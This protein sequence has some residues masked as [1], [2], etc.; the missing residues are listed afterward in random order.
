MKEKILVVE[1]QFVEADYLSL[2]LRNAGYTVT[3]IARSVSQAKEMI[4]KERPG[5]VLLDIYLKGSLTGIELGQ[6]LSEDSI[7]FVYVSANS[8]QEVLN[9]AK[10]TQPYGFIVKPFREQDLLVTLEIARY[11]HEHSLQSKLRK[12]KELLARITEIADQEIS[13]EQQL[14]KIA[15]AFQ[16]S[17][18]FDYFT[19]GIDNISGSA[20]AGVSFLRIGFNEYQ[21][22]GFKELQT[23][24][25]KPGNDLV[26]L[27]QQAGKEDQVMCRNEK[28]FAGLCRTSSLYK[29]FA[30][31]F[32]LKSQLVLPLTLPDRTIFQLCFFN[33]LGEVY[34]TDHIDLLGRIQQP[35]IRSIEAMQKRHKNVKERSYLS[36][37][38]NDRYFNKNGAEKFSGIVGKS[39]L[40]LNVL[41]HAAL[42]ADTDTSVLIL[43]ESGTGKE[44]I[45]DRIHQLSGRR[46]KVF[47]KVNCAALPATLIES[48]LFGHE[49]GAFT[50]ANEKRTG[51][52]EKADGGT[53]LLDEVGEMPLEL[54]A[55]LLRVLQEKEIERVGGQQTIKV[56]VRIIAATNKNLEAEV[57][58]GRFRLDLYYRLNV[59]PI[60]MPLLRE[61]KEDIP[62]LAYYFIEYFNQKSGRR[63]NRITD[64]VIDRMISYDWPGNIRELKHVIERA[65]LLAK[66]TAIEDILLPV[67]KNVST[68]P[69]ISESRFKTIFENERDH[70]LSALQKCN[71]KVWGVGAAAEILNIHPSTLASKMKKLGIRKEYINSK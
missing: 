21:T 47:I 2:L 61:R 67:I 59:F 55:K 10:A 48:E 19:A 45:A 9:A 65:V 26:L 5:F 64:N 30:E 39:H 13:W 58:E 42:V 41:D 50:G 15:A 24:T 52:F 37:I 18:P 36:T 25:G 27:Q 28:A 7:P 70:I 68:G 34:T 35:L 33:K 20:C 32:R 23:I 4:R 66:G 46:N 57:A 22:I 17:I 49:R 14:G 1:D 44:S 71:G 62:L 11:R 38:A 63:V 29:M 69:G 60:V 43:G 8:H 51:K 40:L 12:E 6:I 56:D 16:S 31:K 53:I 54:Q 3:G